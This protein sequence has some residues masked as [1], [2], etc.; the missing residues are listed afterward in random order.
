M[1]PK[2]SRKQKFGKLK[3]GHFPF[4]L[5]QFRLSA[6]PQVAISSLPPSRPG[7]HALAGNRDFASVVLAPNN[8]AAITW[9]GIATNP[10]TGDVL[11]LPGPASAKVT[12]ALRSWRQAVQ[13]DLADIAGVVLHDEDV[14]APVHRD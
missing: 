4:W 10:G 5:S 13:V 6:F 14:A 3:P 8:A 2:K 12:V 9:I 11:T 1:R 7:H